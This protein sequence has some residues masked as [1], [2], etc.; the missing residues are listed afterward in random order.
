MTQHFEELWEK[1]EQLHKEAET[2]ISASLLELDLKLKFYKA[3]DSKNDLPKEESEKIKTRILGELLLTITN[4]SLIDNINVFEAL[5]QALQFRS[6]E[7]YSE[8]YK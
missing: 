3:V 6:I 1:C 2:S 4:I 5:N 8:K 7:H